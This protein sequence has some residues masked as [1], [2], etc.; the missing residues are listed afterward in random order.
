MVVH[1]LLSNIAFQEEAG[2]LG[3]QVTMFPVVDFHFKAPLPRNP[4]SS[5]DIDVMLHAVYNIE[6]LPLPVI[7]EVI[8]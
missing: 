8:D 1:P 4:S 5:S 7:E 6:T 3:E 2:R